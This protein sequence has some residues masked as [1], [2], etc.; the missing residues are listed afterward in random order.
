MKLPKLVRMNLHRHLN[1]ECESVLKKR[2]LPVSRRPSPWFA[3]IINSRACDVAFGETA[4]TEMT[5]KRRINSEVIWWFL[6]GNFEL[7]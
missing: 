7:F 5:D 2:N 4:A 3:F 1:F 6:V